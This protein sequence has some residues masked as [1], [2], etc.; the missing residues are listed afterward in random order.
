[1]Y[2]LWINYTI[3]SNLCQGLILTKKGTKYERV[4][5]KKW[6]PMLG[7]MTDKALSLLIGC[8]S[9]AVGYQRRIKGIKSY[10]SPMPTNTMIRCACGCGEELWKYDNR[11]RARDYLPSHWAKTQERGPT[12]HD[13]D[14]TLRADRYPPEFFKIREAILERDKYSCQIC[15]NN[16]D[17]VVHHIDY[18]KHNNLSENLIT[19][20]IRCHAR[21]NGSR[22]A[23]ISFFKEGY[24]LDTVKAARTC[25]SNERRKRRSVRQSQRRKE[26]FKEAL[27]G[28][29]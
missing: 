29:D 19:L 8:N 27:E 20:C 10:S 5:W 6:E 3:E 24:T 28:G 7:T 23:W 18:D 1:M 26:R 15:E 4:D 13:R 25:E 16:T 2:R 14:H 22:E 12:W 21:T 11:W 9:S 17:Q